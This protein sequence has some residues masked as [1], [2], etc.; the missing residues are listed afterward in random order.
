MTAKMITEIMTIKF[1]LW[2]IVMMVMEMTK[3]STLREGNGRG[4]GE[5]G[6]GGSPAEELPGRRPRLRRI[7]SLREP[8]Y[9]YLLLPR[10]TPTRV[11][12]APPHARLRPCLFLRLPCTRLALSLSG[13]VGGMASLSCPSAVARPRSAGGA[14]TYRDPRDV[15]AKLGPL[16]RRRRREASKGQRT[17]TKEEQRVTTTSATYAGGEGIV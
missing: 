14:V 11:R 5:G 7:H 4:E 3:K 12:G 13:S 2:W 10:V 15:W 6:G 17:L 9:I 16:R 1:I 8:Q